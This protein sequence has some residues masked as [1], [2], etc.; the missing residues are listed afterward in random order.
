MGTTGWTPLSFRAP[1]VRAALRRFLLLT[2]LI[3]GACLGYALFADAAHAADKGCCAPLAAVT[4]GVG[5]TVQGTVRVI[6]GTLPPAPRLLAPVDRVVG[7]AASTATGVV[8]RAVPRL[9]EI[10]PGTLP[11]VA[12]GTVPVAP[13]EAVPVVVPPLPTAPVVGGQ[14][15]RAGTPPVPPR[16]GPAPGSAAKPDSALADE[17]TRAALADKLTRAGVRGPAGAMTLLAPSTARI[18]SA[19][20]EAT[21]TP[22]PALPQPWPTAPASPGNPVPASAGTGTQSGASG[23]G[24]HRAPEACGTGAAPADPL[25]TLETAAA[26]ADRLPH[27]A[28][29]RPGVRPD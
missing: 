1:L 3:I 10:V 4:Q 5:S 22:G 28:A 20:D 26:T 13:P 14:P 24:H 21:A 29:I 19:G 18:G 9:P 8:G 25:T 2:G 6:P 16:V 23:G 17:P 7:A 12:P 27:A 15:P 11:G